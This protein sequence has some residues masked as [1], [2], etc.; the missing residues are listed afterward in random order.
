MQISWQPEPFQAFG[1]NPFAA[2]GPPAPL[3]VVEARQKKTL[4]DR[5]RA[6]CP[7]RPGVYGMVD[8]AGRLIYVGKSKALRTRLLSYFGKSAQGEK[9]A[10]I[11]RETRTLVWEETGTDFA[12]LLRELQLIR[13]WRPRW[14]VKDQ[15]RSRR[16]RYLCVGRGPARCVFVTTAPPK[17][18]VAFGPFRGRRLLTTAAEALNHH[19][20]L[21]DC[22]GKVTLHWADQAELFPSDKRPGCLRIDLGTCLGP[23]AG[24]CTR[25]AYAA[26][27]EACLRWL[28]GL[29]EAADGEDPAATLAERMGRAAREMRFETAAKLR[30]SAAAV[31]WLATRLAD[32]RTVRETFHFVYPTVAGGGGPDGKP[33]KNRDAGGPEDGRRLWYLIERGHVAGV[34]HDPVADRRR[35]KPA[36]RALAAWVDDG[37]LLPRHHIPPHPTVNLTGHWFRTKPEELG[38]VLTPAEALEACRSGFLPVGKRAR[39]AA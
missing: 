1:P 22:T 20:G 30:D 33:E 2:P 25:S 15:P 14:N 6:A 28:R 9:A 27:E 7:R 17:D 26:R 21:R 8:A 11:I 31:E 18:A 39:V 29:S 5:M 35:R 16:P 34:V 10:K 4:K 24:A 32:L 23:C 3:H 36:E 19:F 13:T 37:R 12:S 38:G